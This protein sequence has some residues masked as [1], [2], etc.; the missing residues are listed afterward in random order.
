[1]F[2]WKNAWIRGKAR[3]IVCECGDLFGSVADTE[4]KQ[5]R[6]IG[7]IITNTKCP[8]CFNVNVRKD[9]SA[10]ENR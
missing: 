2:S 8:Q 5:K 9:K 6:K 4:N 7:F 10:P 3:I 1:M